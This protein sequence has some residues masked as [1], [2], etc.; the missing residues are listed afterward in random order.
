MNSRRN[1]YIEYEKCA[2]SAEN[3]MFWFKIVLS[4]LIMVS[5]AYIS[6]YFRAS[7]LYFAFCV[8]ILT[9]I[10]ST[11]QAIAAFCCIGNYSYEW[12]DR[13]PFNEWA[14]HQKFEDKYGRE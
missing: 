10:F 8:L 3:Q 6:E 13:H 4:G 12:K 9:A 5:G 11:L 14:R 2:E 7:R 1:Y